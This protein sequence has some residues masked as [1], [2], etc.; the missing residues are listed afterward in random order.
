MAA[1]PARPR[2][3]LIRPISTGARPAG[4]GG[5]GQVSCAVRGVTIKARMRSAAPGSFHQSAKALGALEAG[6]ASLAQPTHLLD[7]K[8]WAGVQQSAVWPPSGVE[9]RSTLRAQPG[10]AS[11][12]TGS[13]K[14]AVGSR[15]ASDAAICR[16]PPPFRSAA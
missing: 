15:K 13:G 2:P 7:Q 10:D 16:S 6:P 4:R 1:R 8:G 9:V 14:P 12:K 3:N 5:A 11:R